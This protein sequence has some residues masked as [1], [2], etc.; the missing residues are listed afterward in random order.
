MRS[1]TSPDF[2][3]CAWN[4]NANTTP[5]VLPA[6]GATEKAGAS[7]RTPPE[8]SALWTPAK[9]AALGTRH[10]AGAGVGAYPDP[11]GTTVGPHPSQTDGLQRLRLCWGSTGRSPLAG[12]RAKP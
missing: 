6:R 8:G 1:W 3:G 7:P 10:L 5:A 11:V 4:E 12:F 2:A 9:G